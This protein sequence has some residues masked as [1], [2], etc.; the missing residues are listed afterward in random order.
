MKTTPTILTLLSCLLTALAAG[1]QSGIS[2]DSLF[3]RARGEAFDQ[4][5]YAAAITTC[6][7]AVQGS[8][9]DPDYRVFLGRLYSWTHRP[10]SARAAFAKALR[11]HPG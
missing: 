5:D 9:T 11:D 6:R 3:R 8:P 2:A 10:D 1:A 7:L 4:K